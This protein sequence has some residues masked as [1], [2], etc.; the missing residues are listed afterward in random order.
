MVIAA[1]VLVW[2]LGYQCEGIS[3]FATLLENLFG[4]TMGAEEVLKWILAL[5]LVLRPTNIA[6]KELIGYRKPSNPTSEQNESEKHETS[7]PETGAIIGSLER[8]V[9]L[10]LASLG[11]YAAIALVIADKSMARYKRISESSAFAEYYL[12]GTLASLMVALIAGML[13]T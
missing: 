4:N 12:L 2:G 5:L 7:F 3:V 6:L 11:Q 8:V 13:V 10:I 1:T 9:I